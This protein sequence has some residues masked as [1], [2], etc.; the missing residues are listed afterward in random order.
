MEHLGGSWFKRNKVLSLLRIGSTS[1]NNDRSKD[2]SGVVQIL[3]LAVH[4][5]SIIVVMWNHVLW[6]FSR[7]SLLEDRERCFPPPRP[8]QVGIEQS[9]LYRRRTTNVRKE[10]NT[11]EPW[12]GYDDTSHSSLIELGTYLDARVKNMNSFQHALLSCS[13]LNSL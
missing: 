3:T 9:L 12:R 4:H 11:V 1:I 13:F 7:A 8:N 10:L 6:R 2:R 5:S